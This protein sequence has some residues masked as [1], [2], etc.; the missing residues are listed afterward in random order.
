MGKANTQ[1]EVGVANA[2]DL[3]PLFETLDDLY[4]SA[5]MMAVLF[6]NP[7]YRQHLV[8][9][10]TG[11]TLHQQIMLGYSDSGKDGGYLASNWQ[12]YHAQQFLTTTCETHGV[13]L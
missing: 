13:S 2:V 7:T 6:A 3:V 5:E 8:A 4:R 12:L 11:S 9:R 10:S 1:K